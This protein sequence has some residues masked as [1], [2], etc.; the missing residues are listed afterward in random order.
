MT[1]NGKNLLSGCCSLLI[2]LL[3]YWK[4]LGSVRKG[5]FAEHIRYHRSSTVSRLVIVVEVTVGFDN[6]GLNHTVHRTKTVPRDSRRL[7]S[8]MKS[9]NFSPSLE[10]ILTLD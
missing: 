10:K 6:T 9:R 3:L 7:E 4:I 1:K 8:V 5:L 2:Y